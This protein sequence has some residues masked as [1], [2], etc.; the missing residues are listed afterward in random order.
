MNQSINQCSFFHDRNDIAALMF[1][2]SS[3]INR[4]NT[5]MLKVS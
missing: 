5:T 4:Y 2:N 1:T 3:I